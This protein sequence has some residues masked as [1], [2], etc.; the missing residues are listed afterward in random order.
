MSFKTIVTEC[1]DILD[2]ELTLS[3]QM[4]MLQGKGN[5]PALTKMLAEFMLG[6]T[7]QDVVMYNCIT[8]AVDKKRYNNEAVIGARQIQESA[9]Q[10]LKNFESSPVLS[11]YQPVAVFAKIYDCD[12]TNVFTDRRFFRVPPFNPDGKC[13]AG[14]VIFLNKATNKYEPLPNSWFYVGGKTCK[15]SASEEAML[16]VVKLL[17]QESVVKDLVQ[18]IAKRQ[19]QNVK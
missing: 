1:R 4:M 3:Q 19:K 15:G 17:G 13:I 5:R 18:G 10:M 8:G 7:L 11:A 14:N 12:Y 6:E 16:S 9:V 2:P